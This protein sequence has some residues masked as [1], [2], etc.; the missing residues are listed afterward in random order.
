MAPTPT[1]P[2]PGFASVLGR[3]PL[4]PLAFWSTL[5]NLFGGTC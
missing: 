4:A 1:R 2:L 3:G 5:C